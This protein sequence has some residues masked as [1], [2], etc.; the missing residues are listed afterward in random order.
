MIKLHVMPAIKTT[1]Y[2]F[3]RMSQVAFS[4]HNNKVT[5]S[6]SGEH[7]SRFMIFNGKRTYIRMRSICNN[8]SCSW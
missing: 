7:Y 8:L 5:D 1:H 3:P 6:W 2:I 4:Q